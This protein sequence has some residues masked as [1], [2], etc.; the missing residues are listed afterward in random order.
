MG[1]GGHRLFLMVEFQALWWALGKSSVSFV[2]VWGLPEQCLLQLLPSP[3]HPP[4]S[5]AGHLGDVN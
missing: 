5:W 4:Q 2:G 3:Y 1:V